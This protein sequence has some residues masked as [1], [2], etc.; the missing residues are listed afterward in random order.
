VGS[1]LLTTRLAD[2]D[3]H[4]RDTYLEAGAPDNQRLYQR[5]GFTPVGSPIVLPDGTPVIPMRRPS[6][7]DAIG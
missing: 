1:R 3:A 5:L 2:L 7:V 4:G 6:N